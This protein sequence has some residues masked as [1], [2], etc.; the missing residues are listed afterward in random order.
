VRLAATGIATALVAVVV[1]ALSCW[2]W[3]FARCSVCDG[4]GAHSPKNNRRVSRPC[5]WCK[6]AGRRLRIG[7]RVANA[8]RSRR[9]LGR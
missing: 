9:A 7:R 8:V 5:W 2:V 4:R 1:Y 3:P 6:G